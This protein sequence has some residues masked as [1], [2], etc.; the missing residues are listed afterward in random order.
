[1]LGEAFRHDAHPWGPQRGDLPLLKGARSRDR[2]LRHLGRRR[3]PLRA[4]R[5]ACPQQVSAD[6]RR[7]LAYFRPGNSRFGWGISSKCSKLRAG[8]C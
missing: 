3:E 4:L 6:L 1:M 5:S 7:F 2:P 8:C